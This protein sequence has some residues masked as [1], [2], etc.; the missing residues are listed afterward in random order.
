M[1]SPKRYYIESKTIRS[2]NHLLAQ[3]SAKLGLDPKHP[4][5]S[6]FSKIYPDSGKFEAKMAFE[7]LLDDVHS[8]GVLKIFLFSGFCGWVL[9]PSDP[10]LTTFFMLLE[11][12]RHLVRCEN[13][14]EVNEEEYS[15]GLK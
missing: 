11:A 3:T 7:I 15:D 1:Q 13:L 14:F 8:N 5:Q 6:D 12:K 10:V 9:D 4:K 2:L